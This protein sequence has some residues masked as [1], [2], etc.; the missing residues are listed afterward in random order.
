MGIKKNP[1]SRKRVRDFEKP[2]TKEE[3]A[4]IHLEFRKKEYR[5]K[6]NETSFSKSRVS[7]LQI[8]LSPAETLKMINTKT[9]VIVPSNER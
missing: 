5:E 7:S 9:P 8:W 1:E 6:R 2:L 4:R 3:Q